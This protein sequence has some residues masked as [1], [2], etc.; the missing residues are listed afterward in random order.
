MDYH[1]INQKIDE[2]S[3]RKRIALVAFQNLQGLVDQRLVQYRVI[4]QLGVRPL[5]KYLFLISEV[6]YHFIQQVAH[7][8]EELLFVFAMDHAL[9]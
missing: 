7:G 1:F 4:V 9:Q 5:C 2:L 8:L 3:L 6:G